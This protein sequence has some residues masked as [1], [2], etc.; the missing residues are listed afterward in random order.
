MR[1]AEC[2]LPPGRVASWLEEDLGV[3]QLR[4]PKGGGK[5]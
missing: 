3:R 2:L 1:C 5:S 4:G